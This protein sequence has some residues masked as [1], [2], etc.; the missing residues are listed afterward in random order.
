MEAQI[1]LRCMRFHFPLLQNLQRPKSEILYAC[2][3]VM[4]FQRPEKRRLCASSLPVCL[5]LA[6]KYHALPC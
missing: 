1:A 6:L 2:M 5:C 3:C 4:L